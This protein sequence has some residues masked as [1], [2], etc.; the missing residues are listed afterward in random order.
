MFKILKNV[1]TGLAA[2]RKIRE[3]SEKEQFELATSHQ[4]KINEL[5]DKCKKVFGIIS[6]LLL[7]FLLRLSSIISI[8]RSLE[9]VEHS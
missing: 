3:H 5:N 4:K 2:R 6:I 9:K 7:S 1:S 8:K